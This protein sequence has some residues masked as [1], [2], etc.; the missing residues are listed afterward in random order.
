MTND[1]YVEVGIWLIIPFFI[2]GV[3]ITVSEWNKGDDQFTLCLLPFLFGF[4]GVLIGPLMLII[5]IFIGSL[6]TIYWAITSTVL[7]IRNKVMNYCKNNAVK[8]YVKDMEKY[9]D[10]N[11]I[12]KTTIVN[13]NNN[14]ERCEYVIVYDNDEY[15]CLS[16]RIKAINPIEALIEVDR[17]IKGYNFRYNPYP[18]IQ[19]NLKKSIK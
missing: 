8:K 1:V 4:L 19:I 13:N 18:N 6:Y 14:D 10:F 11:P 9:S 5:T 3:F 17:T 16:V 2:I 7:T 12:R 15:S